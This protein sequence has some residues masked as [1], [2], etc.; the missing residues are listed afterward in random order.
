MFY[1]RT[2]PSPGP[3]FA[4]HVNFTLVAWLERQKRPIMSN[5]DHELRLAN[6]P[7]LKHNYL[8]VGTVANEHVQDEGILACYSRDLP[9]PEVDFSQYNQLYQ[10]VI[11]GHHDGGSP[12]G[13]M[14]TDIAQE[15]YELWLDCRARLSRGVSIPLGDPKFTGLNGYPKFRL[16]VVAP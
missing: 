6:E 9:K 10:G 8:F 16:C 4:S 11:T 14:G 12:G 2:N 13:L 7:T 3:E 1:P 5:K 15:A